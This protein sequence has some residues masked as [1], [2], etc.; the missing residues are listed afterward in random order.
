MSWR[1]PTIEP[2]IVRPLSTMSKMGAGKSPG[3]RPLNTMVPPRRASPMACPKACGCTAVTNTPC[4]P[5]V[6]FCTSATTS[7]VQ[8]LTTTSAPS[9]VASASLESSTSTATTR[10]PM[11]RAYCTANVAQTDDA[12]DRQPLPGP[13]VGH[14]EALV[15]DGDASAQ[16]GRYLQRV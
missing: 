9:R 3:G 14:L 15:V 6:A 13:G 5:P 2:R 1:G 7:L 12:G 11:A 16:E 4:T 10:S 8:A